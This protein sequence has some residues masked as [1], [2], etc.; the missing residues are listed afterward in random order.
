M[1]EKIAAFYIMSLYIVI[2]RNVTSN[3]KQ[4]RAVVKFV[5]IKIKSQSSVCHFQIGMQAPLVINL[6]APEFYI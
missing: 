3:N 2:I 6:L 4:G 5:S 1:G